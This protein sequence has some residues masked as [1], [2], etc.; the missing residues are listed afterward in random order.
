MRA[1]HFILAVAFSVAGA[2]AAH[3]QTYR[4][5]DENGVVN[6]S[7]ELPPPD[8]P[9]QELGVVEGTAALSPFEQRA[10]EIINEERR[11]LGRDRATATSEVSQS[12]PQGG[13]VPSLS[14]SSSGSTALRARAMAARD[15]CLLSSDP[16][17]FEKNAHNYDP[18]LGYAP[19]QAGA[20]AELGTA[21]APVGATGVNGAGG[22]LSGRV[23]VPVRVTSGKPA[24][25]SSTSR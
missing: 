18:Y 6:F 17:C 23:D 20:N 9:I 24:E 3:A 16:R 1:S 25:A 12:L 21:R 22:Q 11:G 15:P 4:W 14:S 10:L 7:Q 8:S 13:T 2:G 19:G 5:I